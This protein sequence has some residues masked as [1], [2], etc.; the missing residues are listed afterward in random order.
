MSSLSYVSTKSV[1]SDISSQTF[2]NVMELAVIKN[3]YLENKGIPCESKR[4]Y[5]NAVE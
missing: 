2:L 1:N 5:K 4:H 3:T